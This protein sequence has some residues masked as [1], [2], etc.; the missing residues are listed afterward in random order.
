MPEALKAIRN[1]IYENA[2]EFIGVIRD[3]AFHDYF[4]DLWDGDML[5]MPPKG[6]PRDFE[7][8]NLLRYKSYTV[9]RNLDDKVLL[10]DRLT[11]ETMK[12]F[13][14]LAPLVSFINFGL[15]G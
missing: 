12:A 9:W 15:G 13:G 3:K 6:Y 7:H 11:E 2:D 5:K 10:G 1:E 8:I 14:L 4:G